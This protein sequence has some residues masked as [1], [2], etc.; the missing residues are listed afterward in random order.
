M[1]LLSQLYFRYFFQYF[2]LDLDVCLYFS[3]QYFFK[4]DRMMYLLYDV[5]FVGVYY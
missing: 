4:N 3:F 1:L 2:F 5:V